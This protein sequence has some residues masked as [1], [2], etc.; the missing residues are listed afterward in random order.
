MA[1]LHID[2]QCGWKYKWTE[3]EDNIVRKYYPNILRNKGIE[4]HINEQYEL[5]YLRIYQKTDMQKFIEIML[6]LPVNMLERKKCKAIEI[7]EYCLA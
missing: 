5:F 6:N 2:T 7:L 4:S 3:E 1:N